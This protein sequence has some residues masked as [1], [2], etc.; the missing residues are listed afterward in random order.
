MNYR[1]V[2]R[3][4]GS[5]ERRLR[6][7]CTLVATPSPSTIP[8]KFETIL[9][10]D[11][12]ERKGFGASSLRFGALDPADAFREA[13]QRS[14]SSSG[15]CSSSQPKVRTSSARKSKCQG[16]QAGGRLKT[17]GD[18]GVAGGIMVPGP[19]RYDP[20]Q[21]SSISRPSAVMPVIPLAVTRSEEVTLG[22][23]EY[24]PE[25]IQ[26][27]K[28]T[29]FGKAARHLQLSAA[30][31]ED[32]PSPGHYDVEERRRSSEHVQRCLTARMGR[33]EPLISLNRKACELLEGSPPG[34]PGPGSYEAAAGSPAVSF[35]TLGLSSFQMGTSHLPR[36]PRRPNPGPADYRPEAGRSFGGDCSAT[37]AVPSA[38]FTSA[39][40]RC[41]PSS[42][43]NNVPGPGCYDPQK[44]ERC[45]SFHVLNTPNTWV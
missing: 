3:R 31:N 22:P 21:C 19:G 2:G 43:N 10:R 5:R 18:W 20:S 7:L 1:S 41:N 27:L 24:S 42:S 13:S 36:T 32:I 11:N 39:A 25:T 44:Q 16:S 4:G 15:A 33:P 40:A 45:L 26:S 23:G 12:G 8:A 38:A 35:S 28:A 14:S 29:S 6:T 17:V 9:F 37:R 30:A 34:A